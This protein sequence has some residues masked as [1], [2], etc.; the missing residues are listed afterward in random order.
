MPLIVI[1]LWVSIKRFRCES[2]KLNRRLRLSQTYFGQG[3]WEVEVACMKV[4]TNNPTN[5]NVEAGGKRAFEMPLFELPKMAMPG[6]FLEIAEQSAVRV[7]ENCEKIKAASGEMADALR[8]TYSTN[9]KA[10]ADYGVKVIEISSVNTN[11]AFDFLTSLIGTKSVSEIMTLSAG[12]ARKTFEVAS[13]QN[14]ELWGLAQKV[15]TETAEPVKKSVSRVL[16]KV[17]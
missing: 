8:E 4:E 11:S 12:Q 1:I 14:M 6:I 3:G 7:K 15:A 5:A 9:A 2:R 13:A 17:I 10:S 16:Q